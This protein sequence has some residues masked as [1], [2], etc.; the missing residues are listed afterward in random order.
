V[1]VDIEQIYADV[2]DLLAR[3]HE[4]RS[5]TTG[6]IAELQFTAG[7]VLAA[8]GDGNSRPSG[9]PSSRPPAASSIAAV[10]LLAQMEAGVWQHDADLRDALD[11]HLNYDRTWTQALSALPGLANRLPDAEKHDLAIKLAKAVRSWRNSARVHLGHIAPMTQLE[12][13]CPYC[14]EKSLIVRADAGSDVMCATDGCEDERGDRPRW[15]RQT[16]TLLLTRNTG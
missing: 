3:N 1:K 14:K 4:G 2:N 6:L 10:D 12:A 16:W 15:T 11:A 9:K 8:S 7:R 5:H 13:P